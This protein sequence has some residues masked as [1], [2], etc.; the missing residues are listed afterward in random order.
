MSRSPKKQRVSSSTSRKASSTAAAAALLSVSK[1]RAGMPSLA[2]IIAVKPLTAKPPA[3]GAAMAAA[4]EAAKY[5]ILVTN[6]VD[7]YE[8]VPSVAEGLN[9]F[10]AEKAAAEFGDNFEGTARKA[11]KL[12][13][14]QAE[15]EDFDDLK[16]LIN[17]LTSDKNMK[18]HVPKIKTDAKSNRVAE[19]R[20]NIRV[21]AF[22]YA[23]SRED[24]NDF[25][26][27]IGRDPDADQEMYMTME[28]SGLPPAQSKS[29]KKLNAAR[30]AYKKFFK[31]N[32]PGF[33][34]EFPNP[35]VPVE[36]EGSL[37][38]D[39]NHASGSKPGPKDLRPHMPTIWEVHPITRM[40]FEP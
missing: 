31:N 33:G 36:I 10:L 32:M 12:S 8:D 27:I 30:N 34:Y 26:L 22:L 37:F 16:D 39:M 14:A 17:S 40:K 4:F 3:A 7:A 25:H 9:V 6:Q 11:A 28:L 23:A 35:P 29:F 19:E 21:R 18:N 1:R 2:S 5:Q 38:F 20:R 24:D 13:I 15:T